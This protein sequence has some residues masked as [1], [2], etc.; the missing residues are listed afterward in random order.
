MR[1][2][3]ATQAIFFLF[4]EFFSCSTAGEKPERHLKTHDILG[5]RWVRKTANLWPNVMQ[6]Q[7]RIQAFT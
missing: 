6:E 2:P 7:L 4:S 1:G 3:A 5:M